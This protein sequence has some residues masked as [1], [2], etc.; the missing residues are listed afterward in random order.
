MFKIVSKGQDVNGEERY[1]E[2][3]I[4]SMEKGKEAIEEAKKYLMLLDFAIL[5]RLTVTDIENGI[6]VTDSKSDAWGSVV[7]EEVGA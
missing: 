6:K 4:D 5:E 2:Y 1:Q 7:I 3:E